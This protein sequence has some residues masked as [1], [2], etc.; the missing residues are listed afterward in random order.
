MRFIYLAHSYP[1][2]AVVRVLPASSDLLV[3]LENPGLITSIQVR[4][5]RWKEKTF[6][7]YD[8]II[9]NTIP[10]LAVTNGKELE[11]AKG[12]VRIDVKKGLTLKLWF[13]RS[14]YRRQA[15]YDVIIYYL[16]KG[17]LVLPV[18][19]EYGKEG[20]DISGEAFRYHPDKIR[21]W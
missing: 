10:G 8:T 2:Q 6:A 12:E 20:E 3:T 9:G 1:G 7:T 14:A 15:Y 5:L 4:G 11:S 18:D 17:F 19:S 13:P 16:D 21:P